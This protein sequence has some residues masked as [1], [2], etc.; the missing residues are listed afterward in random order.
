[1][2]ETTTEDPW[3]RIVVV[4]HNA[5]PLLQDCVEALAKQTMPAFEVVIVDNASTVRPVSGLR[6]PDPRFRVLHAG[7]NIGFAAGSNLGASGA[8][9]PWIATL[10]PDT[11]PKPAWLA[12]L[13]LATER[14]PW[15][16]LFGSTQLAMQQPEIVD[17]FGDVLTAYGTAWR[18]GNGKPVSELPQVDCEVV[19]PC[20]AA[21]LY[22]RKC[23]E[24]LGGFDEAFFCYLEDLDLGF[25]ARLQGERCVQVRR[26]EVLH[27]ASAIAGHLSAF[28]MFHSY[29]NR[30]WLFIKDVPWPLLLPI[31]VLQSAAMM[32]GVARPSARSYRRA[33]LQGLWEGVKGLKKALRNRNAIQRERLLS[34]LDVARMMV[35]N[36]LRARPPGRIEMLRR[37]TSSPVE[38]LP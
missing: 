25:R 7:S 35:W 8:A 22:S 26:A 13:R 11:R 21:A 23:F 10:N 4:N 1:M 32:I 36:P 38:L 19:S 16:A 18:S 15:A 33:A 28:S 9:A 27:E 31:A 12:E 3:V 30:I 34:T 29:R 20:A 17:G 24:R 37:L 2:P 5:G 6:L 14:Y